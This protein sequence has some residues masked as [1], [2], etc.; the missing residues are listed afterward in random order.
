MRLPMYLERLRFVIVHRV[1]YGPWF[2]D[3]LDLHFVL[4]LKLRKPGLQTAFYGKNAVGIAVHMM[5]GLVTG[6]TPSSSR[7]KIGTSVKHDPS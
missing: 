4:L 1:I 2:F 5:K 7:Y 3:G 6:E